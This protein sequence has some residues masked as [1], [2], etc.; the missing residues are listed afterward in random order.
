MIKEKVNTETSAAKIERVAAAK[1]HEEIGE[2]LTPLKRQLSVIQSALNELETS[3]QQNM[4]SSIGQNQQQ[5]PNQLLQQM[6]DFS[7]QAQQQQQKTFQQLQQTIHQTAQMLGNVEQSLQSINMLNQIT[8][9]INQS[10]QTLQQQQQMQGQS[11]QGQSGQQGVNNQSY[12]NKLF[13][14]LIH[15]ADNMTILS[16]MCNL[17]RK[18]HRLALLLKKSQFHFNNCARL[19]KSRKFKK[20]SQKLNC[21]Y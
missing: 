4:N 8:Q 1:V 6:Q 20:V 19:L 12:Y 13:C 5:Q 15:I 17:K 10:Q 16:A 7:S 11:Q 21:S 14:L 9:Q 18:Y 2:E 3:G